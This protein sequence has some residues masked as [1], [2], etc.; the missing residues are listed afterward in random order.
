MSAASHGEIQSLA[1]FWKDTPDADREARRWLNGPRVTQEDLQRGGG[2]IE[3]VTAKQW[4]DTRAAV[5]RGAAANGLPHG[6]R[7]KPTAPRNVMWCGKYKGRL[8]ADVREDDPN[9]FAWACREMGGF[10]AAVAKAGLLEDE[11]DAA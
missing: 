2:V 10:R 7:G 6:S 3:R 9:Y 8:M 11:E 5:T 1:Q 4:F